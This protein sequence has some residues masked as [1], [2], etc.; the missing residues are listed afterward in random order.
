LIPALTALAAPIAKI[1]SEY[2]LFGAAGAVSLVAFAGLILAPTLGSFSR[3][4]EKLAAGLLTVFVL[5][6][7]VLAGLIIGLAIFY[8]WDSISEAI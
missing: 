4:W 2:I 7:L 5:A 6:A 1:G 8:N 3:A